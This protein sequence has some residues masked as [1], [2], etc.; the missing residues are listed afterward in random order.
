MSTTHTVNRKLHLSPPKIALLASLSL[1]MTA[2]SLTAAAPV[3]AAIPPN[4]ACTAMPLSPTFAGFNRHGV[5]L[6]DF[7]VKVHCSRD[8]IVT[9]Q[10]RIWEAD[11]FPNPDD[12]IADSSRTIRV[13][14]GK[15]VTLHHVRTPIETEP[16]P[17][18][19]FHQVRHQ[20]DPPFGTPQWSPWKSTT[21]RTL[22]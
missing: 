20:E 6:L 3:Q 18:E 8:R 17:E 9:V 14:A 5:K 16:G 21:V 7:P 4:F 19:V 10:H 12:L 1:G 2:V 22:P 13:A 11:G 15:T